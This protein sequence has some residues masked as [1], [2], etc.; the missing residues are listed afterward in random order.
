MGFPFKKSLAG[1]DIYIDLGTANT[2]V[3][4]LGKGLIVNEPSVVAY[5]DVNGKKKI[6]AV[7]ADAKEKMGR[8]PGNM[9]V[10]HP[11]VDGV[12]ADLDVTETM[13]KYFMQKPGVIKFY[14]KPEVVISLPYGVTDVEKKACVQ[15]G[16]SA[17]A[18]KVYLIDEP[19]ASAVGAGL[20]VDQP[21]A[22][23]IIDIGGGTTEVAVI[24]LYGIVHCEA[25]RVGGHAFDRDIVEY[26][27]R[28]FN[29]IIGDQTAEKVKL[30]VGTALLDRENIK[31]ALKG[32]DAA[33]GL[34]KSIDV[35]SIDICK[36]MNGSL[37]TII[38]AVHKTLEHIP[39][40]LVS[41]IIQDGII[42]AG[43]GALIRDMDERLRREVRVPIRLADE[44]LL[45][46]AKG[47][48]QI[49][50]SKE[51]LNKVMI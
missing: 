35:S 12:I 4:A 37:T 43:G 39:P 11:L 46:I 49:I 18:K 36:A 16:L 6:L 21:K 31:T 27:K 40:E 25:V 50:E 51:F 28:N 48:E 41:D 2:L 19:M 32:I 47:G 44:P 1:A 45:T 33:T 26:V 3:V 7:G 5:K 20:R 24:S 15:A 42:L 38:D 22:S 23:M 9:I 8:A 17:G 14:K 10:T 29:L 34:P 30:A 13:L